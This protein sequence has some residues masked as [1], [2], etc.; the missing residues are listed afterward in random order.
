MNTPTLHWVRILYVSQCEVT[1]NHTVLFGMACSILAI[2]RDTPRTDHVVTKYKSSP[3]LRTLLHSVVHTSTTTECFL[4][5]VI[6]ADE[7]F[8]PPPRLPF[9][10]GRVLLCCRVVNCRLPTYYHLLFNEVLTHLSSSPTFRA[11]ETHSIAPHFFFSSINPG[12]DN[13]V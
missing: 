4:T 3:A 8:P 13:P 9:P 11:H 5:Q 2:L 6:T 12:P 7:R 10:P 1:H